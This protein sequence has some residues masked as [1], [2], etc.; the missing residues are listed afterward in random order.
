MRAL[1]AVALSSLLLVAAGCGGGG[2]TGVASGATLGTD[3]A[4]LVP[5]DA[6][7]FVSVDTNLDSAQWQRVD[8][9]TKSFPARA[10]L[11]DTISSE[12]QKRGLTWKDDIAP[13]LGDELDL[14]AF[15]D[16]QPLEYVA[17]AMFWFA[18]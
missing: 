13:A 5:P 16:K 3:A 4:Q 6:V 1:I 2:S 10:K 15:G 18:G 17:Y 11:L 9:L 8:D 12:L 7:A 14:A